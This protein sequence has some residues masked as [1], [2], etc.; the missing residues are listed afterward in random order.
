MDHPVGTVQLYE[1]A[2][3]TAVTLKMSPVI[4]GQTGV[5]PVMTV[6]WAGVA[7]LTTTVPEAQAEVLQVP[8]ART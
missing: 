5:G 1:V 4:P 8:A 2:S 6:G 3:V 7:G